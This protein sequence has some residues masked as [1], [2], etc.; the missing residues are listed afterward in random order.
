MTLRLRSLAPLLL[1][2]ACGGASGNTLGDTSRT[3]H[4]S[5]TSAGSQT[6][7][8]AV[9]ART[10]DAEATL[11][12]PGGSTLRGPR[13]WRVEERG[14]AVSLHAPEGE[15]SLTLVEVDEQDA[16]RAVARAW[17][18]RDPSFGLPV[19]RKVPSPAKDG[20]ES[21]LRVEYEAPSGGSR[22]AVAIARKLSGRHHVALVEGT[23]AGLDRRGAQLMAAFS[24]YAPPGLRGESFAGKVAH[25]LD[26]AR[27]LE[28]VA[29][30]DQARKMAGIP[31]AAI[32]I[33]RADRVVVARGLGDRE[34][35][36]GAPVTP[37]TL[38]LIGSATKSL[39]TMMMT[40]LVDEGAFGWETPAVS[41]LPSLSFADPAATAKLTMR[42]TV[43]AC[44]GLPRRDLGFVFE[45]AQATPES[46]VGELATMKPTTAF[47]E[48]FQ[49]SNHLVAAGGFVAAHAAAPRS[50]LGSAYDATMRSRVLAPLG[51]KR[52]TFDLATAT[53]AG[54]AA[55]HAI[56]ADVRPRVAPIA[57]EAG[58]VAVRPA[59]G[60]WSSASEMARVLRVELGRGVLDGERRF[61]EEQLLARRKAQI[62]ITEKLSYGLGLFVEDDHGVT[63]V[64]HPGDNMGYSAD[65]FFLPD[66]D[67]GVVLLM[68]AGG[69]GSV[70][71]AVRRKLLEILFDGRAEAEESLANA[72]AQ[73]KAA[74]E[75]EK[76]RVAR[77]PSPELASLAGT[78][79]SETLG[80]VRLSTS[81]DALTLDAGEWK[82]AVGAK[83]SQSGQKSLFLLDPPWFGL[84]LTVEDEQ[85]ERVLVATAGQE[86]HVFRRAQTA[87][88][89]RR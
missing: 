72:V 56:G 16:E 24:S 55:P 31:G 7:N 41:V 73:R 40:K 59:G 65:M 52:S 68:N 37:D 34:L 6:L 30:A 60:L 12:T 67:V 58:V 10:L 57:T 76:G 22:V 3:S 66:H 83:T 53:R 86:R 13:G 5:E 62:A 81:G 87:V 88:S 71:R 54:R 42:H 20:W 47:G 25:E 33:V 43:C 19:R 85:G 35:G 45:Y 84:S 14:D 44:T 61:S 77:A 2:T 89:A 15:P 50:G 74:L 36:K 28:L 1:L 80:R 63:V 17:A 23:E 82:S 70:R 29:F 18:A 75:D 32:A 38:F 9:R 64:G 26:E 8:A 27:A 78:Y 46:R 49:Y 21:S 79:Q 51:M 69:G 48:A 4:A 39:T 11:S